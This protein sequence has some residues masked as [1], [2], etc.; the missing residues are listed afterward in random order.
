MIL[1]TYQY[2]Q[3]ANKTDGPFL[4]GNTQNCIYYG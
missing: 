2:E 4:A 3:N 1:H